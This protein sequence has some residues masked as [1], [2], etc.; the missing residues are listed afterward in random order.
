MP[1][2]IIDVQTYTNPI[3]APA[4]GD[5]RTA[6]SVAT[7]GQGLANRT[8]YLGAIVASGL[9]PTINSEKTDDDAGAETSSLVHAMGPSATSR[10]WLLQS[11]TISGIDARLRIYQ[12][13]QQN[14]SLVITYNAAWD[15][16]TDQWVK[17][18]TGATA[19]RYGIGSAAGFVVQFV[20]SGTAGPFA[21][22][23]WNANLGLFGTD[24]TR[25]VLALAGWMATAVTPAANTLYANNI[26]KAWANVQVASGVI[27]VNDAFNIGTPSIQGTTSL[28]LPFRTAMA[29]NAYI[30]TT[31]AHTATR[32][33]ATSLKSTA[34]VEL[35]AIITASGLA[36]DLTAN[37]V[38]FDVLLMGQQ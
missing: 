1:T 3:V 15:A 32:Y 33:I 30:A 21:E 13:A 12:D 38:N 19:I 17:D 24:G 37:T 2:N 25:A 9:I 6:A 18:A 36:T 4:S 20:D 26:V 27:T 22:G 11:A 7:M 10:F 8:A 35:Q 23:S 34:H 5:P 14:A 28:R 31:G 29:N 16:D